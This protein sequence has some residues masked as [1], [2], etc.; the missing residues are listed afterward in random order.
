[1]WFYIKIPCMTL[2]L[3][4]PGYS[5]AVVMMP[6]YGSYVAKWPHILLPSYILCVCVY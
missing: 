6:D 2:I 4:I 3:T 5:S 1:M